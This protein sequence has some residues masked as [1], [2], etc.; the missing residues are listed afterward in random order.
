MVL[1]NYRSTLDW[2]LVPLAKALRRVHPDVLTWFAFAAAVLGGLAFWRS[3]TSP[4]GLRLLALAWV[5][6]GLNSVLDLLDGKVAQMTGKA[7]P[8][9]DFLDHAIDRASDVA[10]L[11]GIAFSPWARLEVGTFA[12]AITLLVSYM[13]TQAQAVGLRRNYGGLLGRADRMVI[14]LVVPLAQLAVL[15]FAWPQPWLGFTPSLLDL[16]L[17]YF[18]VVGAIA[19]VQRFFVILGSFGPEGKLK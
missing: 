18:A 4:E 16:A 3:G 1:D 15:E 17:L 9:G 7:S 8:R 2:W 5:C 19:L 13:G 10:L 14:L 6:V 12:I 11:L